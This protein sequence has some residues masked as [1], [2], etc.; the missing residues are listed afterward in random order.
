MALDPRFGLVARRTKASL[1]LEIVSLA[2]FSAF[3]RNLRPETRA[4]LEAVG[5]QPRHG[6]PVALPDERGALRLG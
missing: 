5:Y 4:F 3:R 1:P 6:A 2:E